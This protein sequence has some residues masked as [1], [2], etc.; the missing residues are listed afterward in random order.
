MKKIKGIN[1]SEGIAIGRLVFWEEKEDSTAKRS[2]MDSE[3][4]L[5][6]L[7]LGREKAAENLNGIYLK[8]LQLVGEKDSMIFQIHLMMLEDEDFYNAIQN[9]IREEK[10]NAEYAIRKVGRK[11]SEQFANMEDNAPVA[12]SPFSPNITPPSV[13]E[14]C[15]LNYL[16]HIYCLT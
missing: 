15:F 1:A 3:K 5:G 12:G 7:K 13:E 11:F 4:E 8:S 16:L 2:V 6:R 14:V 10:V 9:V